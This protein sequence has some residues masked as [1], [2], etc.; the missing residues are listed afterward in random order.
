MLKLKLQ[1]FGHLMRRA[2]CWKRTWCWEILKARGEGDKRG[3]DGWMASP[4]KLRELVMDRE[5]WRAAVHGVTKSQTLLNNWNELNWVLFSGVFKRVSFCF[6][7]FLCFL[8]RR[9]MFCEWFLHIFKQV[10]FSLLFFILL[11]SFPVNSFSVLSF[12]VFLKV[13]C[14]F[15]A[16]KPFL[17]PTPDK[18]GLFSFPLS[19]M[20]FFFYNYVGFSSVAQLCP[21]LCDCSIPGFPVH[22]QLLEL[23]Q[24]HIHWVGDAI[25]PSCPLSSSSPPAF[26]LSQHQGLF[27]WVGSSHQV[28]KVLEFQLHHQSFQWT[29]KDWFPLG[30]TGWIS[31]Q[32]KGLS[33]VF[34]NTTVQKHQFFGAQLSL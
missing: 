16:G 8:W 5:A 23:A 1:Y 31:L 21:T 6:W 29:F 34:S 20:I 11:V 3:W 12:I 2:D 9:R 7:M 10:Y 26:N 25:Q 17:P 28:V 14:W 24:T 15:L 13:I 32:S 27:Q 30:W 19:I 22:H 4:T 33:T 18:D